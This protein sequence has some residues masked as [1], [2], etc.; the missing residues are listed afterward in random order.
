M[1]A[2]S[3]D[4][5]FARHERVKAAMKGRDRYPAK[6]PECGWDA[7]GELEVV[8]RYATDWP[9]IPWCDLREVVADPEQ[10]GLCECPECGAGLDPDTAVERDT[11]EFAEFCECN[12]GPPCDCPDCD[13]PDCGYRD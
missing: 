9:P 10:G 2:R 3:V 8:D 13:H 1:M 7:G 6:C 12:G 5:L 11:G 4:E